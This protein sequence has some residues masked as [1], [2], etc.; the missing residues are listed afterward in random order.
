MEYTFKVRAKEDREEV[1]DHIRKKWLVLTP[2]ERV[3]QQLILYLLNVKNI[4]LSHLSVEKAITVN[5]LTRR[6]DLVVYGLDMK[7]QMVVEC[8]APDVKIT[9]EV[10][11]QA[12]RYN[13]TLHAPV[14]GVTNGKEHFF[15]SID[16][17]TEKITQI[18]F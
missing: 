1:F 3:R 12:G 18:Q 10:V 9:Q 2:E 7:P 11:E 8:K 4:P 17:D 13:K 15:F 5:G 6:Y 14:L 16:F